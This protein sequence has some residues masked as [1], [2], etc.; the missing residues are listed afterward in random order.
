MDL[1]R[2]YIIALSQRG[3]TALNRVGIVI[4]EQEDAAYLGTCVQRFRGKRRVSPAAPGSVCFDR[5]VPFCEQT[6]N[7]K[8]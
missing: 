1:R 5:W 4:Q 2:S 6:K 7:P 3:V 8:P